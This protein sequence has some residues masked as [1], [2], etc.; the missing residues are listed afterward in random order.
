M[1]VLFFATNSF[2]YGKGE[3]LILDEIN[4]L[5]K[6]FDKIILLSSDA[7]NQLSYD[8]PSNVESFKVSIYLTPIQKIL[9]LSNLF[10]KKFRE[11]K[12]YIYKSYSKEFLFSIMKVMV[13]SYN[14]GLN[15]KS[16]INQILKKKNLQQEQLF[17]YSYWC[18][19][20]VI[21]FSMIKKKYPNAKMFSR[22]HAY[23]LYI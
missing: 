12:E 13:N 9:G 7:K 5:A 8:L 19:E 16:K 15:Y 23:D 14:I 22:F 17:F 6:E 18:T 1:K 21:G 2:P 10:S 11:E 3:P 4:V 20:A